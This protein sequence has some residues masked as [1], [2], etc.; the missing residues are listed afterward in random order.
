M[1]QENQ[2]QQQQPAAPTPPAQPQQSFADRARGW[3][4]QAQQWGQQAHQAIQAN[5]NL[6]G[7]ITGAGALAALY[8]A[9]QG[10]PLV[11]GL[12]AAAAGYGGRGLYKHYNTAPATQTQQ[13]AIPTQPPAVAPTTQSVS[14]PVSPSTEQ[15]PN[16]PAT[17]NKKKMSVKKM[18]PGQLG[19]QD[20]ISRILSGKIQ[21]D[22]IDVEDERTTTKVIIG[23]S[24]IL[25]TS[26]Q[27][28][29][30]AKI[31]TFQTAVGN[32]T[33]YSMSQNIAFAP[34]KVKR[35]FSFSNRLLICVAVFSP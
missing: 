8:G 14:N 7:A 31:R 1:E 3:G 4:Q 11:A 12:G 6:S 28:L 19:I 21:E 20:I 32:L 15:T 30:A 24:R 16:T 34:E 18:P 17:S 10:N 22:V 26:P 33:N 5:P 25:I 29:P 27:H 9:R 13:A 2:Q 35:Q 23:I